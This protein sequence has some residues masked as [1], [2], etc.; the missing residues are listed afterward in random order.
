VSRNLPFSARL[1]GKLVFE[2]VNAT[3]LQ[4]PTAAN[5]IAYTA[6]TGTLTPVTRLGTP[7][8]DSAYPYGS[9]A[10]RV[11]VAFRLDF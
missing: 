10:R 7:I 9:G 2:V 6:I 11:Q 8:S 5:T 3:N 1:Q 4:N